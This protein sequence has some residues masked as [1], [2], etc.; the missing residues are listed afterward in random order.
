[1]RFVN[2]DVF[3]GGCDRSAL[4]AQEY[5]SRASMAGFGLG[6]D[7]LSTVKK[8]LR[9]EL[10]YQG[11]KALSRIEQRL[12]PSESAAAPEVPA[13]PAGRPLAAYMLPVGVAAAAIIGLMMMHKPRRR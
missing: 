2:D 4:Q 10:K 11:K 12:Q 7:A 3:V 1:M 9:D 8:R 6:S 5:L 13:P